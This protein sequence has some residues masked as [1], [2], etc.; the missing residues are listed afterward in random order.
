MLD[1]PPEVITEILSRMSVKY[2]LQYRCVSKP[3]RSLLDSKDF[4]NLQLQKSIETKSHIGLILRK[5]FRL[6][7]VDLEALDAA[8]ELP[9][10]LMCYN[11]RIR[12]LGFCN[13][14]LCISN[15]A[16]DV[17]MWNPSTKRHRVLPFLPSASNRESKMQFCGARVYGFGYDAVNEDYKLVS[18]SQFI[19]LDYNSFESEVK[20]YSL[21]KNSWDQIEDMPYVLCY[22]GKMGVLVSGS[23][24]WVVTRKLEP[25]EKELVV[26]FDVGAETFHEVPIPEC[27]N[28]QFEMGVGILGENLCIVVN[29]P[30]DNGVEVWVMKEYGSKESWTRLFKTNAHTQRASAGS[31]KNSFMPLAYSK[32]GREVLFEQD[33][34]MLAWFDLKSQRVKDI[35]VRGM[36]QSFEALVCVGSL[37]PLAVGRGKN[38]KSH[39]SGDDKSKRR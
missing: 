13:G 1:L 11:N 29:Y 34:K 17:A 8:V 10:P 12:I 16:G 3:W 22:T 38:W 24:H 15:V 23:L 19:G 25:E 37:V 6:Y 36:P 31:S 32:S 33:H 7:Y 9:H 21:R 27:V 18:I 30:G 2:I 5:D 4:A 20:V 39:E 35:K 28:N 26:G 14:L